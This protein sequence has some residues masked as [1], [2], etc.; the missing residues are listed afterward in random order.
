VYKPITGDN[1]KVPEAPFCRLIAKKQRPAKNPREVMRKF[2]FA[3]LVFAAVVSSSHAQSGALIDTVTVTAPDPSASEDGPDPGV[4]EIQRTGPTNFSLSVFYKLGGSA[5]NGVDYETISSIVTIPAGS[6]AARIQV[7]PIADNLIEGP[8]TVLLQ[9][10]PSPL[11]CPS[12]ACG[13]FIGWPS[14]ATVTIADSTGLP[15]TNHPPFVQLNSPR[16]G[17]QFIAPA[18]IPLNAYAQD[19]EDGYDLTVEFFEGKN[20]L[21]LGTFVPTRCASPFCPYYALTWS[22]ATPGDYIVTARATDHNGASS[23]SDPAYITVLGGVNIYAT[24][25]DATELSALV[26][27]APDTATFTVRRSGDTSEAITVFYA[28]SGTA[29]NG[30]DYEK[31]SG[32]VSIPAGASTADIR[33][34]AIDDD[35]VEGTETVEL[36][37][38]AP[39][40]PCLFGYPACEVAEGTNCYP[41]GTHYTAVAY[42]HDNDGPPDTNFPVVTIVATDPIAV[43]GDFC[44][45]NWWW[46]TSAGVGVWTTNQ[47]SHL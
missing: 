45:S 39:C 6:W 1:H 28:I 33:V 7:N 14:N 20:S 13:Y 3:A 19:P 29:S 47:Y 18:D 10:V 21:G 34:T 35:L 42:I 36:T 46:T 41:I 24:D 30:V 8:E 44:G 26:D 25:P 12:P 38:I 2:A 15:P 22:N 17:Q 27:A 16:T 37:L 40:P 31:L 32:Q 9:I 23:D 5:S 4:F 43:E 11:L